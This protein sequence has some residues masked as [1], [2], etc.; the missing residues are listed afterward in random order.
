M[1]EAETESHG[2]KTAIVDNFL[3]GGALTVRPAI[4]FQC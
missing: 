3:R 4:D 2:Y 1:L